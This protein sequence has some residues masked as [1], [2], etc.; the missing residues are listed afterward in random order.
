MNEIVREDV[1]IFLAPSFKRLL[2]GISGHFG[3]SQLLEF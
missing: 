1:T 2:M 3:K